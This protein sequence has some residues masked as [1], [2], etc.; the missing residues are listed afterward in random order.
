[1]SYEREH[2][3][4]SAYLDGVCTW[5]Q[6]REAHAEIRAEL[7]CHIR[8]L[9][10][11]ALAEGL[12]EAEALARAVAAMGDPAE[13]GRQLH[14]AHRPR[15]EWWLLGA[16][17]AMVLLGL[18]AMYAVSATGSAFE[19]GWFF[20]RQALWSLVGLAGAAA[21]YYADYRLLRRW[22]LPLY[23]L[24]LLALL[25][26][27]ITGEPQ[28]GH[29][30][31]DATPLLFAP[32]LAGLFTG[33]EWKGLGTWALFLGTLVAPVPLYLAAH[34]NFAA[35]EYI[36]LFGA[37][38]LAAR[39]RISF[40]AAFG[41][42]LAGTAGMGFWH[43]WRTPYLL[44][45]FSVWLHAWDDPQDT[46]YQLVQSLKAVRSAGFWGKGVLTPV[47]DLPEVHAEFIFPFLVH[48]LGWVAGAA[49]G[50]LV[51]FFVV[52]LLYVVR[53]VRDPLG[54]TLVVGI[55]AVFALE[56]VY[57][58]LMT[59]GLMPIFGVGLPFVSYGAR[60]VLYMMAVGLA[61]SVFRRKDLLP[62]P[63]C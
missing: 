5:V 13:V 41:A 30:W 56:C 60:Q 25:A 36:V 37:V 10:E 59:L 57:N 27:T 4:V 38:L 34:A 63:M 47:N 39:P 32:A 15:T 21:A 31:T 33:R 28:L 58:L 1:M 52:R 24:T 35:G 16:A 43:I 48:T 55:A 17:T 22:A 50:A 42:V 12:P 6:C 14:Q 2:P 45:R 61:L 3:T 23:G 7:A 46:G 44:A 26:L 49:I 9:T 40:I 19:G 29:R 62:A 53:R 54:T 20:T 11:A 51:L 8:D 18:W